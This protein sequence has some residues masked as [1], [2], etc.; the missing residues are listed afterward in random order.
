MKTFLEIR[1]ILSEHVDKL[2]ELYGITNLAV[3][4][5]VVRGEATEESDVDIVADIP[6]RLNLIELMGVE[7]YLSDLLG[8]NVDLIPRGEIRRELRDRILS[9]AK[10]V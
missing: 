10:P 4:G 6:I 7:L 8:A 9:E 3:F 2:R 5:S 1:S